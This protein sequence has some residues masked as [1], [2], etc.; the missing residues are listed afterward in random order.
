MKLPDLNDPAWGW[1]ARNGFIARGIMP[2]WEIT[3]RW[4]WI[5]ITYYPGEKYCAIA[6]MEFPAPE[7]D[8]RAMRVAEEAALWLESRLQE[9]DSL[10]PRTNELER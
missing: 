4:G 3:I 6:N 5:D 10:S 2:L 1:E 9:T 8:N 7:D